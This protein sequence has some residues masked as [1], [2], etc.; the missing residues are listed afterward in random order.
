M[1][2]ASPP[3][4]IAPAPASRAGV[5]LFCAGLVF[6]VIG[7]VVSLVGTIQGMRGAFGE[8]GSDGV[9]SPDR[10]SASIGDVLQA[11]IAGLIAAVIGLLMVIA[12]VGL[13]RLRQRWVFWV[14]MAEGLLATPFGLIAAIYCLMNLREFFPKPSPPRLQATVAS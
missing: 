12:A 6:Q 4:H 9:G 8:L 2:A 3:A 10:L 14:C 13:F 1:N 5:R 11:S 7:M